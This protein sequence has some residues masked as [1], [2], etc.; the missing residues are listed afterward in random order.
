MSVKRETAWSRRLELELLLGPEVGEQPALAHLGPVG[1]L[2]DGQA[3][4]A[5]LRRDVQR[6]VEDR[7]LVAAPL[8][9]DPE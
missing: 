2:A 6:L 3:L 9:T 1:E 5:D 7:V 8:L 4:E